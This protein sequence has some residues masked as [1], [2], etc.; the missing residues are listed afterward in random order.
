MTNRDIEKLNT[1]CGDLSG[2]RVLAA[3]GSSIPLLS[4]LMR[5]KEESPALIYGFDY[6]PKQVAYNYFLK[7]AIKYLNFKEFLDCFGY[8]GKKTR[9][10]EN[11]LRRRFL[12]SHVPSQLRK[13]VPRNHELTLRD[14]KLKTR[15]NCD[16]FHDK[17]SYNLVRSNIHKVKYFVFNLNPDFG[18]NLN[19]LFPKNYINSIYLS[20]VLDWICWHNDAGFPDL[21]SIFKMIQQI[22][23]SKTTVIIDHLA[24]RTTLLPS[25]LTTQDIIQETNYHMYTYYWS[26]YKLRV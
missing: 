6:S 13:Y 12:I 19:Q 18:Q 23:P 4:F 15:A 1:F 8:L 9:N 17:N 3:S 10:N 22:S 16:F 7:S 21:A 11:K 5:K 14:L 2:K 25:F 20:N 26:V 24:H